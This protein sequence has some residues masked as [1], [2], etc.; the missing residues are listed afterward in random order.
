MEYSFIATG[1]ENVTSLHK[2]TFEITTDKY[3]TLKGDC[4]IGVNSDKTLNDLPDE[5]KELIMT[6][7]T[8]IELIL[9]TNNASD[10]I[11]GYGSSNL[12][13]NHPSDMV[14]RKSTFTC[15]RTLMINSNKAATD[16][17][18]EL[19]NDLK[20]GSNLKVTIRI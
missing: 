1:H 12:T 3:L 6:D 15:S 20:Q 19:I 2:S 17:K 13:L 14:C 10:I 18:K 16:L 9:E 8:K 11:I 4:I 5:L 7:D